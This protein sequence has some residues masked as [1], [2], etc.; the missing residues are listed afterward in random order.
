MPLRVKKSLSR[1]ISFARRGL[2]AALVDL[3]ESADDRE[4]IFERLVR[5]GV[6]DEVLSR[7]RAAVRAA[8]E[9]AAM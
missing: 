3:L 2:D 6:D 1:S 4:E 8:A 5:E 9:V 7:L